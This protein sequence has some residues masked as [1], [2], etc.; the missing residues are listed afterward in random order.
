MFL[1]MLDLDEKRAFL[2]LAEKM[3]E[4]DG[5]VVGRE[6]AVLASRKAEM[7]IAGGG[8]GD[9]SVEDLAGVFKDRRSRVVALLE[10]FGLAYSDTD[11]SMNEQSLI[12]EVAQH[13]DLSLDEL[14][15]L[16]AWVQEHVALVRRAMVL[17]R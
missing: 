4:A 14:G 15:E 8:D 16:E 6:V 12:A 9:R 1:N 10:L 13:M 17:M 3:I 7:G 5:M 2:L 11:F